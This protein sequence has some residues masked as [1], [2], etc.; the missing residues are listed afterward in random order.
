ML[1]AHIVPGYFAGAIGI[2]RRQSEWTPTQRITL[3][4]AALGGSVAPDFGAVYNIVFHG[5]YDHCT[6]WTHSIF[7]YLGIGLL[8]FALHESRQAR[9]LEVMVGLVAIGGLSHLVLDIV[10]HGTRIF[11]PISMATVGIPCEYLA[12]G[13]GW[14][15]VTSPLF[16]LEPILLTLAFIHWVHGLNLTAETRRIILSVVM[17]GLLLFS[18]AFVLLAPFLQDAVSSSR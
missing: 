1:F 18:V 15:Y 9:F 13:S 14:A 3:W 11:Y 6:L 4:A 5:T 2:S 17:G 8:W 12:R 10:A 7:V 16:L